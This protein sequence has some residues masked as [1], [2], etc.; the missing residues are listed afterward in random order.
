MCIY[1]LL[2]KLHFID[3]R[4]ILISANACRVAASNWSGEGSFLFTSST[5]LYDCSDNRLCNEV[6]LLDCIFCS[7]AQLGDKGS[8]K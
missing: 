3:M 7:L 2:N 6:L 8:S 5:A 1:L 4:C